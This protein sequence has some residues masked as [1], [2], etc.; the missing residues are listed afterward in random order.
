LTGYKNCIITG[1]NGFCGQYLAQKLRELYGNSVRIIGVDLKECPETQ[2]IDQYFKCDISDEAGLRGI[3]DQ[4]GGDGVCCFQLAGLLKGDDL[5]SFLDLHVRG[6]H[7]ILQAF[8]R[9][10]P[11]LRF[12]NVGTSAEYGYQGEKA[13]PESATPQPETWYGLSKCMQ[14]MVTGYYSRHQG[15]DAVMVRTFN[16]L[17]PGQGDALVVGRIISQAAQCKLGLRDRII[18][19]NTKSYRDFVDIRDVVNAYHVLSVNGRSGEVYNVASGKAVKI[20]Q[21]LEMTLEIADMDI[22]IEE[23]AEKPSTRDIPYQCADIT[24]IQTDTSWEPVIPLKQS[25]MDMFIY[26]TK[27]LQE[28]PSE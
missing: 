13:I 2:K 18:I 23:I 3:I 25:L 5:G 9:L 28:S 21:I 11:K 7:N 17:G 20:K 8:S 27:R 16:V 6:T 4:I 1:V 12:V 19:G 10:G 24:K 15:L 22:G 14:T 26:Q